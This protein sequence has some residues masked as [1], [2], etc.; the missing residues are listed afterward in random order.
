ME[1]IRNKIFSVEEANRL[2]PALEGLL[3]TLVG[4]ARDATAV[5]REIEVLAAIA[6][7]GASEESPDVRLLRDKER[8]QEEAL[9]R[10][11]SELATIGQHGCILRDLE[12]GLVDFYTMAQGRVVCLCWR[13][14]EPSIGHW[15]SLDE[16]FSGRRPLSELL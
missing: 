5:R 14:G 6:G 7:S 16:G 1:R 12:L 3:E 11:R 13:R 9:E 2:L 15:H 8:L 10:F 4:M